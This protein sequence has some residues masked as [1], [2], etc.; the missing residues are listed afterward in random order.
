MTSSGNR[1]WLNAKANLRDKF[2]TRVT[3]PLADVLEHVTLLQDQVSELT[4]IIKVQLEM[5]S[6]TT[7]LLGRLL[8]ASSSR[9]DAVEASLEQS[10]AKATSLT[11]PGT[12]KRTRASEKD[13]TPPIAPGESS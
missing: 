11:R 6:Q 12:R 7:E 10:G 2:D 13:S 5:W 9:L 8:A 4:D 1:G 3:V